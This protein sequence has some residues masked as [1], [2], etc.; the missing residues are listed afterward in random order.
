MEIYQAV[1][2]GI[3][4]GITEFLPISSTFHLIF[5]EQILGLEQTEFLKFFT[6]FIQAGGILAVLSLYGRELWTNRH[7][8]KK[9]LLSFIPTAIF[10]F[11][12]YKLIKGFFFENN[13][14]ML[15]VFMIFGLIFIIYEWLLQKNKQVQ[16][17]DIASLSWQQSLLIGLA[18]ALAVLPG[19]SRAGVVILAMMMLGQ[20]RT[21]AA[22]YSF[23][24]AVPTILGT[25]GFDLL[26]TQADLQISSQ[27]ILLVGVGFAVSFAVALI[28]LRWLIRYLQTNSLTIFGYYR[29]ALGLI[30]L[31]LL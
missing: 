31:T 25:A 19:V 2:L 12:F 27:E 29:L 3:I 18:Q 22:K 14:L 26:K 4:E 10:G 8:T 20:K 6:V 1:L 5:A 16:T 30:L 28:V 17:Q 11:A 13:L 15:A 23:L 7:L 21:E 9:V 24:L